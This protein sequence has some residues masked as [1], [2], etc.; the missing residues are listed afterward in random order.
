MPLLSVVL[1]ETVLACAV[2]DD[3]FEE[4]ETPMAER[5]YAS[6]FKRTFPH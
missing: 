3:S 5:N 6:P 4:E 1:Q 2:Q